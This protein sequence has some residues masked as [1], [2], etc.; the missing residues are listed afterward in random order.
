MFCIAQIQCRVPF[1]KFG[2][3]SKHLPLGVA[4]CLNVASSM[5]SSSQIV[6]TSSAGSSTL[7]DMFVFDS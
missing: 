2:N 6:F 5:F 7:N 4:F 3:A 1:V